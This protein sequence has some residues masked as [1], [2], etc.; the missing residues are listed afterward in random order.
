MNSRDKGK[1][2][3]RMLAE[4][5]REAGYKDARRGVQYKGGADSPD[6]I[7]I[8]NVHVECKF[9]EEAEI[10]KWMQQ[11][12]RDAGDKIPTVMWKKSREEWLVIMRLKDF[13]KLERGQHES[14][15]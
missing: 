11:S 13:V 8:P 2:G 9:C 3:E 1:R 12:I 14:D 5:L 6:V 15:D 4:E 7:G 10:R